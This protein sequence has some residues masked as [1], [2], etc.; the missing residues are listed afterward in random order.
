MNTLVDDV[1]SFPLP[2]QID[3]GSFDKAYVQ[4][5]QAI[6][7]GKDIRND[8]FLFS[9]FC[10][11]ITDSFAKKL[12]T[13]L[14]VVSYPQHYD[15]YKQVTDLIYKVMDKGTYVVDER[16]AILPEVYV[17]DVEAKEL[18]EKLGK[19]IPLRVCIAGPLDLYSKTIGTV[20][21]RDILLMF[22]E[23]V[24]RLAKNSILDSKYVKTEVVSLDEP[25]F[26]FQDLFADR[27]ATVDVL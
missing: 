4:T 24:R 10:E 27:D 1:G 12:A 21:Y 16:H 2:A 11:V 14:D 13:G 19:R 25:S 20:F 15:M 8:K 9:N 26:G 17:I 23:T 5:R 18:S 7:T 22:A 3:K 6:S